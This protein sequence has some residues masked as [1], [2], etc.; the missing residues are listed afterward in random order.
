MADNNRAKQ[1][2]R[3]G[4]SETDS[5]LNKELDNIIKQV[6]ESFN[7][8]AIRVISI[9]DKNDITHKLSF[10]ADGFLKSYTQGS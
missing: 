6:E 2:K 5:Y 9:T 10:N 8:Q 7:G 1:I 3:V 4:K